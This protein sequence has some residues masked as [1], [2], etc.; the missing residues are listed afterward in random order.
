MLADELEFVV[1]VCCKAVEGNHHFLSVALEVADMAVEVLQSFQQTLLVW[2][3]DVVERHTSVH[4]ESLCGGNDDGERWLK[5][6]FSTL[7]VVE[8]LST[9]V[10]TEAS[11]CDDVV[12][13]GHS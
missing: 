6:C 3:L 8:L 4:L 2:L 9:E 1:G 13:V 7:D 10:S 5:S 12:T 11:L